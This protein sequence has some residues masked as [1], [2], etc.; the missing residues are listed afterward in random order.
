MK[1]NVVGLP[2]GFELQPDTH[3]TMT[4]VCFAVVKCSNRIG[5]GKKGGFLA[6][7]IG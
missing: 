7:G 6:S 5:E 3:P 1:D 4:L 2:H